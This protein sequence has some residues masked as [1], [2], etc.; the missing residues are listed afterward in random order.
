MAPLPSI[1]SKSSNPYDFSSVASP[2]TSDAAASTASASSSTFNKP[3]RARRTSLSIS[4]S[5]PILTP[6]TASTPNSST[7]IGSYADNVDRPLPQREVTGLAIGDASGSTHG[8]LSDINTSRPPPASSLNLSHILTNKLSATKYIELAQRR[9]TDYQANNRTLA[10][11]NA[12]LQAEAKHH[13]HERKTLTQRCRQLAELVRIY[14]GRVE[15]VVGEAERREVVAE[16]AR[17]EEERERGREEERWRRKEAEMGG[18]RDRL[19]KAR[20][21]LREEKRM[22]REE[23]RQREEEDRARMEHSNSE[24]ERERV[25]SV[26]V[27]QSAAEVQQLQQRVDELLREKEQADASE[28]R[29][30][31]DGE[32]QADEFDKQRQQLQRDVA[33]KSH[34]LQQLSA[35]RDKAMAELAVL[36][37]ELKGNKLTA[38]ELA[39]RVHQLQDNNDQ[40]QQQL[41]QLEEMRDTYA[42]QSEHVQRLAAQLAESDQARDEVSQQLDDCEVELAVTREELEGIEN[43]YRQLNG[44]YGKLRQVVVELSEQLKSVRAAVAGIHQEGQ[45][46]QEQLSVSERQMHEL[47][48]AQRP[49]QL[50]QSQP[51]APRASSPPAPASSPASSAEPDERGDDEEELCRL[52]D[53]QLRV[54]EAASESTTRLPF[55][56]AADVGDAQ[57]V[58]DVQRWDAED[59]ADGKS[60]AAEEAEAEEEGED[61]DDD[62]PLN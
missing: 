7:S 10:R 23:A 5:T 16:R 33:D 22:R 53:M 32:R 62:E 25:L 6:P 30:R 40:L 11:T 21:E 51:A 61:M 49:P 58:N 38:D 28:E 29:Y 24:N 34:E 20:E 44:S 26:Q 39:D 45:A 27:R 46:R 37:D 15:E 48:G 41:R 56:S 4:T 47:I 59:V 54:Q 55:I 3:A 8:R 43:A 1:R 57:A 18:L 12:T 31:R 13:A 60:E 36:A 50:E 52:W 35:A 42:S 14:R 9:L 19:D 2:S 17:V